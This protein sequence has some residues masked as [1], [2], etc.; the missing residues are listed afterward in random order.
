MEKNHL[1]QFV[2]TAKETLRELLKEKASTFGIEEKGLSDRYDKIE[3]LPDFKKKIR[4]ETY[5]EFYHNFID[6]LSYF[7]FIRFILIRYLEANHLL[8]FRH[9]SLRKNELTL[10]EFRR[11]CA[12]DENI[13]KQIQG[14]K[15]HLASYTFFLLCQTIKKYLPDFFQE[16]NR[17][18]YAFF[19]EEI[20]KP[21]GLLD[22][23]LHEIPNEEFYNHPQ[24]IAWIHQYYISDHRQELRKKETIRKEHIPILSQVFT[25][26][27]IVKFLVENSLGRWYLKRV[28]KSHLKK[29][30]KFYI[31]SSNTKHKEEPNALC[32]ENLKIIEPCCGCGNILL[33]A[34][35][36]LYQMYR[37]QG[38]K[39]EDII[40]IIFKNNLY[41]LDIDGKAVNICCFSLMMK[42]SQKDPTFLE[43]EI[44]PHIYEI[45]DSNS[46]QELSLRDYAFTDKE[47]SIIRRSLDAFRYGKTLGSLIKVNKDDYIGLL[48]K[49]DSLP[50]NNNLLNLKKLVIVSNILSNQYDILITN[51]PYLGTSTMESKI[52]D[53]IARDYPRSKVDL[54]CM[55]MDTDLVKE[56]GYTAIVNPDSWMFLS[57]F[58]DL[59]KEIISKESIIAMAHLGMGSFDAVVQTTAFVIQNRKND[60]EEG[61][62]FDLT[63]FK[64]KEEAL[65]QR[66]NPFHRD[67]HDFLNITDSPIAYY[68]DQQTI[69]A[70]QKYKTIEDYAYPR[71]GIATGCNSRNLRLWFEV[72][73]DTI[74]WDAP[75][76]SSFFATGKKYI[77]YNKGGAYR[78]WF[79][80][81]KWVIWFDQE[82]YP[83]LQN[84]GNHLPSKNFYFKECITWSKVT[85][86]LF[87]T[88]YVPQG[89]V[90][91]VAG[92]SIFSKKNLFYLLG[93]TNSVVMQ[94]FMRVL[95]QT[96]NYEVGNVKSIPLILSNTKRE[97]IESL[98]KENIF[99]SKEDLSEQETSPSFK[100]PIYLSFPTLREG[101]EKFNQVQ[102]KRFVA[103]KNNE[104]KLN[105]LFIKIYHLQKSVCEKV[106]DQ[107]V[108]IKQNSYRDNVIDFLS[109][110][111]G[112][113]LGRYSLKTD[114]IFDDNKKL[115]YLVIT[116]TAHHKND[117]ITKLEEFLIQIYGKENLE[118][119]IEFLARGLNSKGDPR[120]LLRN[121]FLNQFY[122]DHQRRYEKHPIY[123]MIDSGNQDGCKIL[124]Y[125]FQYNDSILKV[126]LKDVLSPLLKCYATEMQQIA[127]RIKTASKEEYHFLRN[128]NT[129]LKKQW[130]ETKDLQSKIMKMTE[131]HIEFSFDDGIVSNYGLLEEILAKRI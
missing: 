122:K 107:T 114:G 66:K 19:P 62:Y 110:F 5:P 127:K 17:W 20:L 130:E 84:V 119:N 7:F 59:R 8:P 108:S 27:W 16:E 57:S 26:D 103:L 55:F 120:S 113:M 116:K 126:F 58:C 121:Y 47:L 35:D 28:P 112:N 102:K 90:F 61:I 123:W 15:E 65:L 42:A 25:P 93:F 73:Q 111:V 82:N 22:Q 10:E 44:H 98:V 124:F 99:Y 68:A 24:L 77:P 125:Y 105:R 131:E 94:H 79:Y 76:L 101:F 88:R 48:S 31:E 91:D 83:Y 85:S 72:K 67:Q 40:S 56:N 64:D 63:R 29:D 6:K 18:Q 106:S 37:E 38:Y 39:E 71:Q 81:M 32:L 49:I 129:R 87:S 11:F 36:L 86:S 80:D 33:Y 78:K 3:F 92:C 4:N 128:E 9:A 104:E 51:P 13:Y 12:F 52:K 118:E 23:F 21:N 109:Y 46:I 95:S 50:Q 45:L 89:S 43:K 115:H 69:E 74:Q 70:F 117:I 41:G 60:R 30:M 14:N 34:F 97:E 75:N 96:L 53:I 100:R 54:S 1:F 2:A